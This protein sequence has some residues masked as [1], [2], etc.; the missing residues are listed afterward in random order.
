MRQITRERETKW[1]LEDSLTALSVF[2]YELELSASGL[3]CLLPAAFL[4]GLF[5]D[6][7]D[8][9]DVFLRNVCWLSTD[10]TTISQTIKLFT[11]TAVRASKQ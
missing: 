6:L 5:F 3:V 11:V 7:E 2:L 10:Y 4:L 8:E 9:G 1:R